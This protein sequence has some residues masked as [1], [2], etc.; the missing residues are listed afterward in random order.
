[1]VHVLVM[2]NLDLVL[3]V[4]IDLF[5]DGYVAVLRVSVRLGV[6]KGGAVGR[7]RWDQVERLPGDDDV[8]EIVIGR[9][10]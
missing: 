5:I 7:V 3:L 2:V 6:F 1:M 9:A 10:S 4:R 8:G